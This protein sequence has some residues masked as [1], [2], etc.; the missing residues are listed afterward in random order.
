M[1]TL[2]LVVVVVAEV[3]YSIQGEDVKR[4]VCLFVVKQPTNLQHDISDTSKHYRVSVVR[5]VR[6][7]VSRNFGVSPPYPIRG[8]APV[9]EEIVDVTRRG[10]YRGS[11]QGIHSEWDCGVPAE[12]NCKVLY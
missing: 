9:D 8:S 12:C 5:T 1:R 6:V 10:A 11:W 3:R 2:C 7:S 4:C